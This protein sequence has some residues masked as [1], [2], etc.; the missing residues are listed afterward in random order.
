MLRQRSRTIII[1]VVVALFVGYS[2]HTAVESRR[3]QVVARAIEEYMA[4]LD[5]EWVDADCMPDHCPKSSKSLPGV[6]QDRALFTTTGGGII[7]GRGKD[8][9][10]VAPVRSSLAIYELKKQK[11]GVVKTDAGVDAIVYVTVAK[12]YRSEVIWATDPHRMMLAP[13]T[14]RVGEYVVMEDAILTMKESEK[15]PEA[16]SPLYSGRK[17]EEP[18]CS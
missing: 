6:P 11:H 10:T 12:C 16:F 17:G 15:Y 5:A 4:V 2:V 1:V 9:S 18:D 8:V 3:T 13:S 7:R 14:S